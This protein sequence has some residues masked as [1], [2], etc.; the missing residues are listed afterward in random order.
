MDPRNWHMGLFPGDHIAQQQA[1]TEAMY[2]MEDRWLTDNLWLEKRY[3]HFAEHREGQNT[4]APQGL[5]LRH[6]RDRQ[7]DLGSICA[8][9]IGPGD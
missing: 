6:T 1:T 8:E 2:A 3:E 7:I 4:K 5:T 9:S